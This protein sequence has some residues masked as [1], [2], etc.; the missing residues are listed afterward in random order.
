M[1]TNLTLTGLL[2]ALALAAPSA[3]HAGA[4]SRP[5]VKITKTGLESGR[6][7]GSLYGARSG[8]G[9]Q[10][11]QCSMNVHDDDAYT[12]GLC[13]AVDATN[14]TLHCVTTDAK[15]LRIAS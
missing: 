9:G 3:V 10:L 7:T 12:I 8:S 15:M 1:N 5:A 2:A 13:E 14:V 6:A 11:I 4:A